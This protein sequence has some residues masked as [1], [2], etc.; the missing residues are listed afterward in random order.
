MVVDRQPFMLISRHLLRKGGTV[1][2]VYNV[3]SARLRYRLL[4]VRPAQWRFAS[5]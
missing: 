3:L 1:R 5:V 2:M 4:R